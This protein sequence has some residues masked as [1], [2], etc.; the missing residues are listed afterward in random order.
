MTR[1]GTEAISIK[2]SI[3]RS[4]LALVDEIA[5][6]SRERV[7]ARL[8]PDERTVLASALP[9]SSYP[10]DLGQRLDEASEVHV[11]ISISGGGV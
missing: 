1:A 2:G 10:F 8:G 7:L 3:L 5:P 4:R 11:V 9:S 6:A